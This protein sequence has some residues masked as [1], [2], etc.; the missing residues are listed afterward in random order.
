MD[1]RNYLLATTAT[2]FGSLAGCSDALDQVSDT[3]D[4][5]GDDDDEGT[6]TD[7]EDG[8]QLPTWSEWL[9]AS[10]VV[11]R[12]DAS[13]FAGNARRTQSEFPPDAY[14]E[15]GFGELAQVYGFDEEDLEWLAGVQVRGETETGVMTGS[16][17][18]NEILQHL[19]VPDSRVEEYRGYRVVD[20]QIAI[21]ESGIVFGQSYQTVIDTKEGDEDALGTTGSGWGALLSDV[22]GG[23]IVA[24]STGMFSDPS[25]IDAERS[26][27]KI[28]ASEGSGAAITIY[29]HFDSAETAANVYENRRDELESEARSEQDTNVSSVEQEGPRII[30]A[31]KTQDFDFAT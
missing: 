26:G 22:A 6:P 27:A 11:G 20:S 21:G 16:F 4:G 18:P 25:D 17:N 2:V 9:P 19:E 15:L 8:N 14:Q 24:A 30:I 1:R 7:D 10:A 3:S 12:A 28:N 29:I 5:D 23:T 31:G 13:V